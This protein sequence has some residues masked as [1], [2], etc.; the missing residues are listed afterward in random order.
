MRTQD[1]RRTGKKLSHGGDAYRMGGFNVSWTGK[2]QPA[3]PE[4]APPW[5]E[6]SHFEALEKLLGVAD[7][8]PP[9]C[10][11][12]SNIAAHPKA[13]W[14]VAHMDIAGAVSYPGGRS[15][16]PLQC[17]ACHTTW[18]RIFDAEMDAVSWV[19]R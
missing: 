3:G 16:T 1:T 18:M 8:L 4:P 10:G 14:S 17:R 19:Q 12:C 13:D 9:V 11:R 6:D 2:A 15:I 5:V 7:S